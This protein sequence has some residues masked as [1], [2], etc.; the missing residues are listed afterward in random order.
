M[1]QVWHIVEPLAIRTTGFSIEH[2]ERLRF[3]K[4]VSIVRAIL[5]CER[6]I[7]Q[8]RQTLLHEH[9]RDA[10]ALAC[11]DQSS[12]GRAVLHRLSS[13]RRAVGRGHIVE[14]LEMLSSSFVT[15][16]SLLHLWN[17][18]QHKREA[19]YAE[20][21]VAWREDMADARQTIR[22][23]ARD[24]RL[25]E[26]IFLSNP[27]MY[28]AVCRYLGENPAHGTSRATHKFERRFV[29]YVQ[30]FC[31]KNE[32][33]S[34]FGP[35]NYGTLAPEQTENL[36][37][38]RSEMPLRQRVT[39]P[40]QWLAEALAAKI[41]AEPAFRPFLHPRRGTLCY[42][43]D[44]SLYF[45][46]TRKSLVLEAKT[47]QLFALAD[48][49]QTIE[50]L[51]VQLEEQWTDTWKRVDFLCRRNAML[52]Q[53][54]IP[55]D[56]AHPLSHLAQWLQ[57]LPGNLAVRHSWL[58]VV[59]DFA[60]RIEALAQ[61]GLEERRRSLE[62]L[63]ASFVEAVGSE[64]RR[65]AG[66]MYADRLLFFE[67]CLGD[68]EECRLGGILADQIVQRLQPVLHLAYHYARLQAARDLILARQVLRGLPSSEKGGVPFLAYLQ[69]LAKGQVERIAREPDALD[70]FMT[71]LQ[72][73][74]RD[75]S[76]G[77]IAH[78]RSAD[79]PIDEPQ[80]ID[81]A[82]CTSLDLMIAATNQDSLAAGAFQLVLGEMHPY[83]LLWVFPTAYFAH[84][85]HT[86]WHKALD[87]EV[88]RLSGSPLPTQPGFTRKTKIFPY[89]LPGLTIEL[90]PRYQT[91]D[92]IPAALVTIHESAA[93]LYLEAQGQKLRL[94][95][96]ITRRPHGLDPLAP[97]SFPAVET[98][99]ISLGTHTPRI[100]IDNVVYQR[101]R[102]VIEKDCPG[103]GT[104][105]EFSL[106]LATWRWKERLGLPDEV[107]VRAPHEPK[108]VFVD[109]TCAFSVELLDI[110][111]RQSERLVITEMWPDTQHLWFSS[112]EGRHTC[113][114]RL[115]AMPDGQ[116]GDAL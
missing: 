27:R 106:F 22:E 38:R 47:A 21:S 37:I 7:A 93:G 97:L 107:F 99:L 114:F 60:A 89:Q 32:T 29:M 44:G 6:S 81:A 74:V 57:E 103:D 4:T 53:V 75:H 109:F 40:G 98:P 49:R 101:E 26:A 86:D 8:Q 87:K 80:E 14:G 116:R 108:P 1:K 105:K 62:R 94:Y 16:S 31:A 17:A 82:L 92:A 63:E 20:G 77:H 54:L 51:A 100:E 13:W 9:F 46:G 73:I 52:A 12:Q 96:P 83:P 111:A 104:N 3:R 45:P 41:S 11:N 5:E 64:A 10:V 35:I 19:L 70:H 25:Q 102:W 55:P 66:S 43:Q 61:A 115:L 48:G 59:Q 50:R 91:C 71:H 39:F 30:R 79:L 69:A 2:F 84:E 24:T 90:R 113:E 42:L 34:F 110:L 88:R 58:A 95:A 15:L 68:L 76:D 28:E 78:L 56:S 18:L 65:G 36:H 72:E 23:L 85:Q 67:E 33:Q 112:T